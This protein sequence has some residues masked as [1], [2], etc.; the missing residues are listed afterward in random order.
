M[1]R[2]DRFIQRRANAIMAVLV[3][4]VVALAG[5]AVYLLVLQAEDRRQLGGVEVVGPCREFGP[6]HPECRKQ[7]RRIVESCIRQPSCRRKLARVPALVGLLDREAR[8]D[9][10]RQDEPGPRGGGSQQTESPPSQP[11]APG[12]GGSIDTG[13]NPE[14]VTPPKPEPLLEVD[15]SAD[16]VVNALGVE[17]CLP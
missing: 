8:D 13:N 1:T 11:P 17:V 15:L 14:P 6:D 4:F 5:V 12:N 3:L 2:V 7:A 10:R 9:L 16:C